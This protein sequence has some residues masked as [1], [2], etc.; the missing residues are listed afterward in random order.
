[1]SALFAW[2]FTNPTVLAIGAAV[3]AVVAA[4]FKGRLSGAQAERN[5]QAAD[6]AEAASEAQK[7]DD[8]VAGRAPDANRTELG[9]WSKS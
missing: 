4:W 2:L 6:Q 3:I 7:I 1:M 5:K 9:K 8:A